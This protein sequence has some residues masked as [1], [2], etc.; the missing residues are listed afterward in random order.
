MIY[1]VFKAQGQSVWKNLNTTDR[2]RANALIA[3]EDIRKIGA[4]LLICVFI[5][6]I[7]HFHKMFQ[8]A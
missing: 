2:N 8:L 3:E 7:F 6:L 4:N 5:D 1:G